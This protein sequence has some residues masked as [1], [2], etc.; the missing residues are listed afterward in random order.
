MLVNIVGSF[1]FEQRGDALFIGTEE[2][3]ALV[4]DGQARLVPPEATYVTFRA[5]DVTVYVP[6]GDDTTT[7][8]HGGRQWSS[9][10]CL[11]GG[12]EGYGVWLTQDSDGAYMCIV[13]D[14]DGNS[15]VTLPSLVG[16]RHF[17]RKAM[18]FTEDEK[19]QIYSPQ[20]ALIASFALERA[21]AGIQKLAQFAEQQAFLR[22]DGEAAAYQ[23]FDLQR[24]EVSATLRV[25]SAIFAMCPLSDGSILLV[26]AEGLQRWDPG[27]PDTLHLLHRF[28]TALDA[29]E[30]LMLLWHDGQH[31]YISIDHD[32][33]RDRHTLLAVPLAG[34]QG[35]AVQELHWSSAWATTIHG[36]FLAGQ[37]YLSL[38]RK[39][40]LADNAVLVWAQG[41]PLSPELFQPGTDT[42]V[43][44]VEQVRSATRGKY[45]YRVRVQDDNPNRAVRLA[46]LE[47]GR[48]LGDTCEGPY[49]QVD[50]AVDRKFDGAFQVEIASAVE[51]TDFER[52]FLPAYLGYYRDAC[53]LHPAGSRAR[54]S[55]AVTWAAG[56]LPS[57][58]IAHHGEEGERGRVQ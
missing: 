4:A 35:A 44:E 13:R 41:E 3:A 25:A 9:T 23:V 38:K 45:G 37:N 39:T 18:V 8:H 52:G 11:L 28:A 26:D 51:P 58:A 7:I 57:S 6:Y 27:S 47:L 10:D 19:A 14:W 31:A 49:V 20:G 29:K 5:L 33:V 50:E 24:L 15:I 2:S 55:L 42:T 43:V 21:G 36:G 17:A 53:Y 46:A 48:L 32:H 1:D 56:A 16:P 30:V 54:L 12:A 34:A 22:T 40:L